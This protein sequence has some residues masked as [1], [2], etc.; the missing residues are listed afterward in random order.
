[1]KRLLFIAF[2][3]TFSIACYPQVSSDTLLGSWRN[4]SVSMLQN[5]DMQTGATSAANGKTFSYE[6][7]AKGRYKF[8]GY[9]Q[10]TMY[11]CATSLYNE[12]TGTYKISGS[13]VTLTQKNNLWRK[14]NSCSPQS[15]ST[16]PGELKTETHEFTVGEDKN[17]KQT[18]CLAQTNGENW[19]F[20]KRDS[21]GN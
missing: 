7:E 12:V 4:G 9:M 17:G 19:C 13:E 3:F 6:F 2:I 21:G 5:R 20:Q 14:Q 18:L 16:K 15:D 10:S 8:T 11:G 1:M